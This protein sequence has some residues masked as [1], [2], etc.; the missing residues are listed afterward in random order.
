MYDRG[1]A[2]VPSPRKAPGDAPGTAAH[3]H[4]VA[5]LS[6]GH[7]LLSNPYAGHPIYSTC[8]ACRDIPKQLPYIKAL[9]SMHPFADTSCASWTPEAGMRLTITLTGGRERLARYLLPYGH[10]S[11]PAEWQPWDIDTAARL[12][13]CMTKAST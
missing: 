13:R 2:L 9:L 11:A 7:R 3:I 5:T 12:A 4:T 8:A 6:C 1:G 10:P